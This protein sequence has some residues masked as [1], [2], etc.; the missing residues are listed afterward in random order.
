VHHHGRSSLSGFPMD[1]DTRACGGAEAAAFPAGVGVIDTAVQPFRIHA[2]GIRLADT[3]QFPS[4]N[5]TYPSDSIGPIDAVFDLRACER[6]IIKNGKTYHENC[7]SRFIRVQS[8]Q[9]RAVG[10]LN[11]ASCN[12]FNTAKTGSG[13]R[14]IHS[15]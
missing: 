7:Y 1:W 11:P 3:T 8:L 6:P 2:H 10:V 9:W 5:E 12:R 13:L 14:G 4:F 15:G